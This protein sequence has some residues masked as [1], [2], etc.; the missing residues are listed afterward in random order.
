[1]KNDYCVY[2]H[3]TPNGLVYIGITNQEPNAR[4]LNG[5][6]YKKNPLFFDSILLYGWLNIK[7]EILFS[8]LSKEE[9]C[10]KEIDLIKEYRSDEVEYGF[11]S[12]SGG[13]RGYTHNVETRKKLAEISKERWQDPEYRKK[14]CEAQKNAQSKEDV[15]NRKSE[16]SKKRY[17]EDDA[18]REKFLESIR[19][20]MSSEETKQFYREVA[21]KKWSEPGYKEQWHERMSGAKNPSARAIEQCTL[22]GT[23]LKTYSTC[24]E[25]SEETKATRSGISACARGRQKTAGGYIWRYANAN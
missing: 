13:D 23:L 4:W 3:T 16:W 9:A 1:M 11:N 17:H 15:K 24:K 22:D 2:K 8:G 14:V 6:G 21:R 5:R 18:Y 19:K 12:Q 10:Q 20:H 7:H 25:A